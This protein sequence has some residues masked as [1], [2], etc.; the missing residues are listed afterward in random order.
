M[1]VRLWSENQGW[2][3]VYPSEA[4]SLL[5]R[6]AVAPASKML[7]CDICGNYLQLNNEA[8][9]RRTEPFFKHG[10][11][12]FPYG[13]NYLDNGHW[14]RCP[15]NIPD[16]DGKTPPSPLPPNPERQDIPVY[17]AINGNSFAWE[18]QIP[19]IP[20]DFQTNWMEG[21]RFKI[22]F[23]NQGEC[24]YSFHISRTSGTRFRLGANPLPK[25]CSYSITRLDER[26][27]TWHSV[28][29]A[30]RNWRLDDDGMGKVRLY[31]EWPWE[32]QWAAFSS[33]TQRLMPE[34]ADIGV[35]DNVFLTTTFSLAPP[36]G[37]VAQEV[38][39]TPNAMWRLYRVFAQN[40]TQ[41]TADWFRRYKLN[42]TRQP[43]T[44]FPRWPPSVSTPN[45][46]LHRNHRMYFL[47]RGTESSVRLWPPDNE[48]RTPLETGNTR[49]RQT[50]TLVCIPTQRTCCTLVADRWGT[51]L[52]SEFLWNRNPLA[53]QLPADFVNVRNVTTERP[54]AHGANLQQG[55]QRFQLVSPAFDGL[56]RITTS[57]GDMT[58]HSFAA[59]Q[60]AF[61][62]DRPV[63]CRV[64]IYYA[65]DC[66]WQLPA[67]ADLPMN[68]PPQ[69]PRAPE[70]T[71]EPTPQPTPQ[72]T[73]ELTPT[74]TVRRIP[75]S[76]EMGSAK[77]FLLRC[78]DEAVV[79]TAIK[80]GWINEENFNHIRNL[81]QDFAQKIQYFVQKIQS[82]CTDKRI[83]SLRNKGGRPLPNWF[84]SFL[85]ENYDMIL[86][87]NNNS[88]SIPHK[89]LIF[90]QKCA[91]IMDKAEK[92][93][94]V[95]AS[96]SV[97]EDNPV[98]RSLFSD[99]ER[100]R[101]FK[102]YKDKFIVEER[103]IGIQKAGLTTIP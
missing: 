69:N 97:D 7:R 32:G 68:P 85:A 93:A 96:K 34:E 67:G 55:I 53:F 102:Y 4:W 24:Q 42:L 15:E 12:N 44:L 63:A 57:A 16:P 59:G 20:A 76:R 26:T 92:Q 50:E 103:K 27:G 70:P 17:L 46:R 2:I 82:C 43:T 100:K 19:L 21:D 65:K 45:I 36:N 30:P 78:A 84:V 18:V 81:L 25:E 8:F 52:K 79:N 101:M 74:P 35:G 6:R 56:V 99:E 29:N 51:M 72:P 40:L 23:G 94:E 61:Y 98:T 71:P 80:N 95:R 11:G 66:V 10:A 1:H 47:L 31:R 49:G 41:E 91:N 90:F 14:Q 77:L 64:E 89:A 75:F 73:P 37:V 54:V 28:T 87:V 58:I 38:G 39:R 60:N 3:R 48:R 33:D 5:G 88:N 62:F 86:F 22:S 83:E 9:G 13:G